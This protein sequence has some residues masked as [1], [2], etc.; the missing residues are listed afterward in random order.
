MVEIAGWPEEIDCHDSAVPMPFGVTSPIPVMTTRSMLLFQVLAVRR[1]HPSPRQR[2]E[3]LWNDSGRRAT[4]RTRRKS[5]G[6]NGEIA[7]RAGY[8]LAFFSM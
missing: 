7:L 4:D 8:F 2:R 3:Q 1:S 6:R 5:L